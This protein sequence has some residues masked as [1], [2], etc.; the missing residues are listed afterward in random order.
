MTVLSD[1]MIK[2][3]TSGITPMINPFIPYKIVDERSG[4]SYGLQAASYDM[5]IREHVILGPNTLWNLIKRA[6]GFGHPCFALV[7]TIETVNLPANVRASVADKSSWAR[8]F[9]AVQNTHF[10]PGFR[11]IAMIELTNH[12]ED[13]IEIMPGTPICQFVFEWLDWPAEKPYNGKYQ[14][15]K[16]GQ[17]WIAEKTKPYC[18]FCGLHITG[19]CQNKNCPEKRHG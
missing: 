19:N 1:R 9:V 6:F 8:R 3:V 18:W 4:M 12:S 16:A 5:R 7:S 17:G 13:Q 15:Q 10:D 11:G 14:N 2:S